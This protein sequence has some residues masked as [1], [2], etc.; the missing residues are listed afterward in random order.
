[1][2]N[3]LQTLSAVDRILGSGDDEN[4]RFDSDHDSGVATAESKPEL[5]RPSMFKVIVL[6]DDYTPMEF[7]VHILESFFGMNREKATQIMLEIHTAGSAVVGIFPKDLA[8]TKSEQ[9]NLYAQENNHPL[10]STTE[11]TD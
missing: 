8:E 9:V 2:V 6:N 4:D 10:M 11:M 5:K 1:M 7:V 3:A